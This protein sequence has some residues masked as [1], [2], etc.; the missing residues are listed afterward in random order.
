MKSIVVHTVSYMV[1]GTFAFNFLNYAE[2]FAAPEL[3]CWMRPADDPW[4][5]IGP[6]FQPLRGL[7]FGLAFLPIR[8]TLF[9][10]RKGWL[11]IWWLLIALGILSTFS[12]A[13]GSLEGMVYTI[14][15]VNVS[16]YLEITVQSLLLSAGVFYWVQFAEKKWVSWGMGIAFTLTILL[17]LLGLITESIT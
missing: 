6:M 9:G 1:V 7:I 8:D 4:I 12:P 17:P 2:G 15:P 16:T 11:I 13:P 5:M 10:R 14:L 3:A